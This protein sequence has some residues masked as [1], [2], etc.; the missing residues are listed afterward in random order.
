MGASPNKMLLQPFTSFPGLCAEINASELPLVKVNVAFA[1]PF[2]SVTTFA[3]DTVP[4][5]VP[6]TLN[7]SNEVSVN[8]TSLPINGFPS[9]SITSIVNE[10]LSPAFKIF[11]CGVILIGSP[12][13]TGKSESSRAACLSFNSKFFIFSASGESCVLT[14][15]AMLLTLPATDE[16]EKLVCA[17]TT[18]LRLQAVCTSTYNWQFVPLLVIDPVNR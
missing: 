3:G 6:G 1:M 11:F 5:I 17:V 2:A 8:K 13:L 9:Q 18:V 10:V 16:R 15:R 7:P 4:P 12:Q 14:C